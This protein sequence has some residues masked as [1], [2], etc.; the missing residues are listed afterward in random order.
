MRGLAGISPEELERLAEGIERGAIRCPPTDADLRSHGHPSEPLRTALDGLAPT[1]AI[2]LL[3]AVIADRAE[4]PTPRLELVWTGPET[5]IARSRDTAV[6]VR[7]LFAGARDEVLIAGFSFDHGEAI[8]EPLHAAMRDHGV[9][10]EVYLDIPR[11]SPGVDVGLHVREVASRFLTSNWPFGP[12][13]PSLYHDPRTAEPD[14][15][16]SL[17][18]KCIV[19]D[20]AKTLITSANFTDRGQTRN[21]ELGVLIEDPTFASKVSAQWRSLVESGMLARIA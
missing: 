15:L 14:A 12:P 19:V 11:A 5:R 3:R 1:A 18:A 21:L 20:L 9:D 17:H 4:R 10:V 13:L 2:R 8:F 7:E 6:L 16:A